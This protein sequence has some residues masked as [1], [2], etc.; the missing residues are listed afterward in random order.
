MHGSEQRDTRRDAE[1]SPWAEQS[2]ADHDA[3][4]E[5]HDE[6]ARLLD[7]HGASRFAEREREDARRERDAADEIRRQGER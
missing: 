2:A 6:N 1:G 4:A 5:A 3:S 7:R